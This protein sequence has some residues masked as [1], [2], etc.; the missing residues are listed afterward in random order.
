MSHFRGRQRLDG[1]RDRGQAHRRRGVRQG[2]LPLRHRQVNIS[3]PS[4]QNIMSP[5]Y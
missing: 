1:R 2:L 5:I 4:R 3:A